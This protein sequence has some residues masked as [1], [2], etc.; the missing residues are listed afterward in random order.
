MRR[1]EAKNLVYENHYTAGQLKAHLH[2]NVH[3]A[4]ARTSRVNKQLTRAQMWGILHRAVAAY[5]EDFRFDS[6]H[7]SHVLIAA[8][9]IREFGVPPEVLS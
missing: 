8:N 4:D 2:A 3:L 7:Q 5:P 6:G 1:H 9:V